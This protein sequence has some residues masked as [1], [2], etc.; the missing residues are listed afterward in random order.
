MIRCLR[1]E[2]RDRRVERKHRREGK[3]R[4]E[5]VRLSEESQIT[6]K[7]AGQQGHVNT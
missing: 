1:V 7:D 3:E 6:G 5:S 4:R 2:R